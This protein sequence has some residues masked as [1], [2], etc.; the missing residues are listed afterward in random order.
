MKEKIKT[1]IID[2]LLQYRVD[3]RYST[4]TLA[5]GVIGG[6]IAAGLIYVMA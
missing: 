3:W 1:M 5:L 6:A 4:V 2:Y